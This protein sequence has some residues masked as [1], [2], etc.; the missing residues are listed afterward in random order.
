MVI[1]RPTRKIR[2]LKPEPINPRL[3]SDTALGDWYANRIV[4]D[5][6]PLLLL[7]SSLSLLPV[8]IRAREV[9]TL[10]ERLP[11]IVRDRL[12]RAKWSRVRRWPDLG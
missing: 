6:K 12:L 4:V 7:I 8:L 5:R 1:L 10:P 11:G 3:P 2:E 9:R